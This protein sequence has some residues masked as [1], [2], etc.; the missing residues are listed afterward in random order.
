MSILDFAPGLKRVVARVARRR[1]ATSSSGPALP[2]L[3]SLTPEE[4]ADTWFIR[5]R[6]L[7]VME[8]GSA[9]FESRAGSY[10]LETGRLDSERDYIYLQPLNQ[11]GF[12]F[13]RAGAGWVIARAD[14]IVAK[15]TFM[16]EGE[17]WD[18]VNVVPSSLPGGMPKVASHRFRDQMM[19]F[20]EY[21]QRLVEA[22]RCAV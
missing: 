14:K 15:D 4:A 7:A 11:T 18:V 13:E 22:I 6:D 12:L 17:V 21:R 16:R 1:K 9:P 19:P 2:A 20:S 3:P 8:F 5:L 10:L